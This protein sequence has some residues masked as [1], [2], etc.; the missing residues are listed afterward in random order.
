MPPRASSAAGPRRERGLER[1][2][3]GRRRADPHRRDLSVPVR[4][5][6]VAQRDPH[7]AVPEPPRDH[8][9]RDA[10]HDG[11]AGHERALRAQRRKRRPCC[12]LREDRT[13]PRR[14]HRRVRRA[15]PPMTRRWCS[16]CD[17]RDAPSASSSL[18]GLG[19]GSSAPGAC[20]FPGRRWGAEW[21]K[22]VVTGAKCGLRASGGKGIA[23]KIARAVACNFLVACPRR[24]TMHRRVT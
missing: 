5:M 15:N 16:P 17:Q 4:E 19:G 10:V 8:R 11:V 20:H 2:R 21:G 18:R 24:R 23:N 7:V 6:S 22:G 13:E 3:S 1:H 12:R 9:H 14:V